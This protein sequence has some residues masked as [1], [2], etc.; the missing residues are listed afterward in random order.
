MA[1]EKVDPE[2]KANLN[3]E[4]RTQRLRDNAAMG[5]TNREAIDPI[6]GDH[7]GLGRHKPD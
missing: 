3:H 4:L 2:F 1:D 5:E 7:R 6:D